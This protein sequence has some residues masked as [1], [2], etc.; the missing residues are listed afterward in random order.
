M[1]VAAAE[2]V[3][4]ESGGERKVEKSCQTTPNFNF[5]GYLKIGRMKLRDKW[6]LLLW[7]IIMGRNGPKLKQFLI[8]FFF[9]L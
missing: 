9:F 2:V 1:V 5:T 7:P 6:A 3:V 8:F 4:A